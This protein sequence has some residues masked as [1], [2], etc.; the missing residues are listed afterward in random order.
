MVMQAQD[1]TKSKL[2][3]IFISSVN[4]GM[5]SATGSKKKLTLTTGNIVV[6]ESQ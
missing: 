3:A 2:Q 1:T 6:G 5:C 4:G